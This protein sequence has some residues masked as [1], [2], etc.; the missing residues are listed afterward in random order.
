MSGIMAILPSADGVIE[1]MLMGLFD[2]L[3]GKK[4]PMPEPAPAP[5]PPIQEPVPKPRQVLM[6]PKTIASVG[7]IT[8]TASIEVRERTS[9][10][11]AE[12]RAWYTKAF[13]W[14]MQ[15]V[16]IDSGHRASA[17]D[18]FFEHRNRGRIAWK[19]WNELGIP[20]SWARAEASL[21]AGHAAQR[22]EDA[23]EIDDLTD[24]E[25]LSL[26]KLTPLKSLAVEQGVM[27]KG[28]A[29]KA[30]LVAALLGLDGDAR[31]RVREAANT[32]LKADSLTVEPGNRE[33]VELLFHRINRAANRM[34]R[35]VQ[36][37]HMLYE[38]QG[39]YPYTHVEV[40]AFMAEDGVAPCGLKHHEVRPAAELVER[41]QQPLCESLEC[42][43]S[44][45]P[46]SPE[47]EQRRKR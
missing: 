15:E 44:F 37:M 22:Q 2:W 46:Y 43:C 23:A 30:L 25:A 39:P 34:R 12:D 33:V 36:V 28:R 32:V 13:D 5:P 40:D 7:G 27:P 31:K 38:H 9:A 17:F 14:V 29:T 10:E 3:F 11:I 1:A 24:E 26:L 47:W 19:G 21:R 42:C 4:G 45:R 6:E 18:F 16:T 41:L 8:L 20:L 35:S